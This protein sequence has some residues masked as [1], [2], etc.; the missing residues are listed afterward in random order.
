MQQANK[1]KNTNQA[2]NDGRTCLIPLQSGA[3]MTEW[4]LK[5]TA[6]I[7]THGSNARK[8]TPYQQP[9]EQEQIVAQQLQKQTPQVQQGRIIRTQITI[10]ELLNP[11]Q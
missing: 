3:I 4:C 10:K 8:K 5:S 9:A 6:F 7:R 2:Y 1:G 11:L